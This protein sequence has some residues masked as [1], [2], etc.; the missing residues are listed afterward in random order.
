MNFNIGEVVKVVTRFD[1]LV[2][3][4][5]N[6][7]FDGDNAF[8]LVSVGTIRDITTGDNRQGYKIKV[9]GADF[10]NE[11]FRVGDRC[12]FRTTKYIAPNYTIANFEASIQA[13]N[14]DTITICNYQNVI[15]EDGYYIGF[16]KIDIIQDM[17]IFAEFKPFSVDDFTQ[18]E[19]LQE[20]FFRCKNV[21]ENTYEE[22]LYEGLNKSGQNK[23]IKVTCL[24]LDFDDIKVVIDGNT[25]HTQQYEFV[26]LC[27]IPFWLDNNQLDSIFSGANGLKLNV[28]I[29]GKGGASYP[30]ESIRK[31]EFIPEKS[32]IG[33]YLENGN[34]GAQFLESCEILQ[35]EGD[36]DIDVLNT[37][38]VVYRIKCKPGYFYEPN[39][40]FNFANTR[41][42][43]IQ[44]YK[45]NTV[46]YYAPT[47]IYSLDFVLNTT[48][49]I[50][51]GQVA[52]VESIDEGAGSVKVRVTYMY[53]RDLLANEY[54]KFKE[55][56][57]FRTIF[58][59]KE[60][61]KDVYNSIYVD[62][63]YIRNTDEEGL[64]S[65]YNTTV[66]DYLQ[67]PNFNQQNAWVNLQDTV[68]VKSEILL[69]PEFCRDRLVSGNKLRKVS[70]SIIAYKNKRDWFTINET[71]VD[72]SSLDE[73][74]QYGYLANINYSGGFQSANSNYNR[75]KFELSDN[76]FGNYV[77]N[78]ECPLKINW[79]DWSELENVPEVF[80]DSNKN[81]DGYNQNTINYF[82]K[83]GYSIRTAINVVVYRGITD[84]ETS[85]REISLPLVIKDFGQG[86]G[87]WISADIEMFDAGG[88][89]L[90]DN[91][92]TNG[93]LTTISTIFSHNGSVEYV[94]AVIG[95]EDIGQNGFEVFETTKYGGVGLWH[96]VPQIEVV[97][98]NNIKVSV[99]IKADKAYNISCKVKRA[100]APSLNGEYTLE[101]TS[102][103]N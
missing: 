7:K 63:K 2:N 38:V 83:F 6:N 13:I 19:T 4:L 48:I 24:G 20:N 57:E 18:L 67:Q 28:R 101:Y 60:Q 58:T 1:Y 86:S 42:A 21:N 94:D 56:D 40:V 75:V 95:Y 53:Q 65:L 27:R 22:A 78:F 30:S 70:A 79:K 91:L 8:N 35:D 39:Q 31:I 3:Y 59:F 97:D 80:F 5:K 12:Q 29:E 25:E 47:A 52:K 88:N 50:N 73:T 62:G 103:Y 64:V 68:L 14:G 98:A 74:N 11:G 92:L 26:T 33:Y 55:G 87:E 46:S 36:V 76:G 82:E 72:L 99:R 89:N 44:D 43:T 90:N 15:N 96:E 54:A 61:N 77:Y 34:S 41:K 45:Y 102:E 9:D 93:E 16:A 49:N 69:M 23:E 100:L 66:T 17:S 81:F 71:N 32:E 85:Y 10:Y 37:S 84:I 51:D